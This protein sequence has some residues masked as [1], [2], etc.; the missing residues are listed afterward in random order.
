MHS[1][2]W[3]LCREAPK[4]VD[5]AAPEQRK[6]GVMRKPFFGNTLSCKTMAS[7]RVETSE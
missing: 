3:E 2:K 7:A 1:P 6:K 5:D 4:Q